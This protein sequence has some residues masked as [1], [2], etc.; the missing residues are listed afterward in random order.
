MAIP[1][2]LLFCW[3]TYKLRLDRSELFHN[4]AITSWICGNSIWMFGEFYLNDKIRHIAFPFFLI[5]LTIVGWY[6][7]NLLNA[8][9]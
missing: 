1:T 4:L 8:C 3:L 7:I 6:Y 2:F 9:P 5:G